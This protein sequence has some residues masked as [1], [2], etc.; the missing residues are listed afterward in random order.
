ML[1]KNNYNERLRKMEMQDKQDHFSI[2]KLSIGAA[3]VL[4]GFTFFGLN[5][6]SVKADTIDPSQNVT[7]ESNRDNSNT[8]TKETGTKDKTK[9]DAA[10]SKKKNETDLSTFSGLSSFL[11]DSKSDEVKDT[12]SKDKTDTTAKDKTDKDK[13]ET[14]DSTGNSATTPATGSDKGNQ[15]TTTDKTPTDITGSDD[16]NSDSSKLPTDVTGDTT[17]SGKDT[18]TTQDSKA[19][20]AKKLANDTANDDKTGDYATVVNGVA[21]AYNWNQF[22]NAFKND[23]CFKNVNQP[24]ETKRISEIDIMQDIYADNGSS[25]SSYKYIYGRKL[26][27]K[28]YGNER[29]KID[30]NGYDPCVRASSSE[31]LDL[32]YENLNLYSGDDY[33]VIRTDNYRK[34]C[35]VTFK[36]VEY[37]GTQLVH[38][39][40]GARIHIKGNVFA[41]TIYVPYVRHDGTNS[42]YAD[43]KQQLFEFTESNNSIDFESNCT[44]TGTTFGGNVIEMR[45]DNCN[46]TV[47]KG[48]KVT[49]NPRLNSDGKTLGNNPAENTGVVHAIYISGTGKVDV[50]GELNIN[51]GINSGDNAYQGTLDANRA[52]AIRLND[53]ASQ[54]TVESGGSVKVTTNGDISDSNTGNL[55]YDG[56]NFTVKP[57]GKLS[58]IGKHMGDYKGTL[59]Q[60][61]GIA[62]V[63]NG[64]FEIRLEEDP[65]HPYDKSDPT[66]A[67]NKDAQIFGAGTNPIVLV[68]VTGSD[69]KLIVNNPQSLVLDSHLNTATGT[70]IIGDGND[71]TITNVRQKLNFLGNSLTLPPFHT[72]QVSKDK[73]TKNIIVD[74]LVLL[75]G[76]GDENNK[77][78]FTPELW[79]KVS[80]LSYFKIPALKNIKILLDNLA[81]E[82]KPINYDTIFSKIINE[83]FSNPTNIGY[84]DIAFGPANTSGFLDIKPENV[85]ATPNVD[86]SGKKDGSWTI[87]GIVDGYKNEYD[88]PDSDPK[89]PF[90]EF[91]KLPLGTKAYIMAEIDYG[92]GTKPLSLNNNIEDPPYQ[93]T[94]NDDKKL[95]TAFAGEVTK[96]ENGNYI[97]KVNVPADVVGK[98]KSDTKIKLTPT[99]NFIDYNPLEENRPVSVNILKIAQDTA[100][101]N[102]NSKVNAAND[103]DGQFPK[104]DP[105]SKEQVAL[106]TAIN[107]AAEVAKTALDPGY[108]S[109]KSVYGAGN[110]NEVSQREENALK[111]L[112]TAMDAAQKVVKQI[113]DAKE[114]KDKAQKAIT[115][116]ANNAISRVEQQS[117]LTDAEKA[118]YIDAINSAEK[119][120]LENPSTNKNSIY[121]PANKPSDITNIQN[122]FENKVNKEAAK[123]EVAGYT[124]NGKK[125]LGVSS[126]K[127]DN[128][129]SEQLKAIDNATDIATAENDAKLNILGKLKDAAKAKVKNDAEAAKEGLGVKS[130]TKIDQAVSEA[131]KAIDDHTDFNEIKK[132]M[133]NGQNNVLSKYKDAA[134]NQLAEVAKSDKKALG[135]ESDSN[136]DQ[137]VDNA[138]TLIGQAS[139]VELVTEDLNSAKSNIADK[140]K[141]S[142]KKQ[143]QDY[144]D[145]AKSNLGVDTDTGI[146]AAAKTAEDAIDG[147][148]AASAIG[149]DITNGKNAILAAYKD[150]AKKQLDQAE[151]DIESKLENVKGLTADDIEKAKK[152]AKG[153]LTNNEKTG[154]KDKVDAAETFEDVNTATKDGIAALNKLLTDKSSLGN[155]NDA[156]DAINQARDKAINDINDKTKYP[157]LSD[158]DRNS[159]INT[160]KDDATEGVDNVNKDTDPAKIT[161]D[162]Q[163]AIDKINSVTAT[164]SSKDLA[165]LKNEQKSQTA[166]LQDAAA[167]AKETIDQID[168]KYLSP[169][170]KQYYK[171]LIDK[172]AASATNAINSASN[173]DDIDTAEKDGESNINSDLVSAQVAAAKSQAIAE[174]NKAKSDD[175][176]AI[177][178]VHKNGT[179]SDDDWEKALDAIDNAYTTAITAVSNDHTPADIVTDKNTGINAMQTVVD[180]VSGNAEQAE[181]AKT[182]NKAIADLKDQAQE[183]HDHIQADPNL[184]NTEK[185]DYLDQVASA[186][187]NAEQAVSAADK[188]T[189][190]SAHNA[191]I[192]ELNNIRNNADLQSAR[193]KAL[194][195]LQ[196][197]FN[198]D[199]AAIDGLTNISTAGKTGIKTDLQNAYNEAVNKVK[200]P[201][202][203]TIALIN[204]ASD[205]GITNM[206]NI[207]GKAKGLDQTIA[208]DQQKLEDYAQK[209]IDR[210]NSSTMSDADKGKA[211][212]DIQN[213]RDDA[214][215]EVGNKLTVEDANQAEKDGETSI[216]KAEA[217]ANQTDLNKAKDAAKA[218]IDG[219]RDKALQNLKDVYDTLTDDEKKQAQAAYNKAVKDIPALAEQAEAAIDNAFD[220]GAIS[221]L[222]NDTINSINS[223]GDTANVAMTKV[224]AVQAVKDAA[225]AAKDK[226]TNP[227]DKAGVDDVANLGIADINAATTSST[228]LDIKDNALNSIK[229]IKDS[230]TGDTDKDNALWDKKNK[231]NAELAQELAD[232]TAAIDKLTDLTSDQKK[233]FKAQAQAA[234]DRAHIRIE[235]AAETDIQSEKGIGIDNIDKALTDAKLQA[236]KNVAKA[237]VDKTADDAIDK[238][239]KDDTINKDDK[240]NIIDNINK[241]RDKTKEDIDNADTPDKVNN[242]KNDGEGEIKGHVDNGTSSAKEK[243]T[244]KDKLAAAADKIYD[245]LKNDR[246]SGKLDYNQYQDLKDKV[247]NAVDAANGAISNADGTSNINGA[248]SDGESALSGINTD[249]DK[250]E[251]V[252]T[253]LGKL[254]DAVN[255]ANDAAD[256]VAKEVGKTEKEQQKL[257]KQMKDAIEKQRAAAAKNIK[258]AQNAAD[259]PLNAIKTAGQKGVDSITGLTNDYTDKVDQIKTLKQKA[260]AAK[261]DLNNLKT[262]ENGNPVLTAS[263][264][265]QGEADIDDAVQT[266][267]SD[268]YQASSVDDA[269]TAEQKAEDAVGL[270]KLPTELLAEKNKQI[271]AINQYAADADKTIDGFAQSD[272]NKDGLPADTIAELKAQV[273]AAKK[274]AISKINAV[275]LAKGASQGDF[276]KAKDK[277]DKAEKGHAESNETVDFG[278]AGIDK[279]KTLAKQKADVVKAKNDKI[280]ELEQK[281]KD[282]NN[283]IE[284]SGMSPADQGPLKDQVQKLV[285]KAKD[286]IINI[287]DTDD[288]GNVKTPEQVKDEA[289]TIIN[290]TVDGFKDPDDNNK[291]PGISDIINNAQLEGA[292]TTAEKTL[293]NKR[294]QA[295]DIINGSQ[296]TADQKQ[297]ANKAIDDAFNTE[298]SDIDAK[299]NIND[300]PKDE[301]QIG[302]AIDAIWNKPTSSDEKNEWFNDEENNALSG[303][304]GVAG[305]ETEAGLDKLTDKQK[306]DY[307]DYIDDITNAITAIKDAKNIKDASSAYDKGMTSLNKL[308]ALEQVKADA[309]KAKGD[310][311]KSDL[312]DTA[313]DRLKGDVEKVVEDTKDKLNQI[314]SSIGNASTNKDKIDQITHDAQSDISTIKD[315]FGIEDQSNDVVNANDEISK[316]HSD[317]IDTI[318]NEFGDDS[319]TPKTDDAYEKNKHVHSTTDEGI[320]SDKTNADKEISKGAIDDAADIAKDKVNHLKHE[321]GTDYTDADKN[322][323]NEQ[324]DKDAK[325]AKD[326]IDKADKVTDIDNIRNNGIH[327][328]HQD[329]SDPATIDN[330][331]HGN[332]SN[333]N[334]GGGGVVAPIQPA[335]PAKKPTTT[336]TSD[337]DKPNGTNVDLSNASDVTLMHNAYLYDET[338]KRANK[339]TLGAGSVLTTYDTKTING[340]DYYVLVDKGANNK[341]YYV[342]VGNVVA[343]TRKLKHNAYIYNQFGKRVKNT[344]VF[345]KGKLIKTFGNAVKIRG[346]KYFII[347]KNRFVKAANFAKGVVTVSTAKVEVV[348]TSAVAEKPKTIVEKTLMHNA[349]LYDQNGTRANKLIFQAGSKVG[350][351]GKK[352]VNG[353]VCYE[354]PDGMFIAAGNIDAKKLKLKH[355]AYVYNQYGH[356]ANKKVLKK[357]K[358]VKTYGNSVKINGK[359]YFIISKGRFVKKANF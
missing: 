165:D 199:N 312:N 38:S 203:N 21:H 76:Q 254:S 251:A 205:A 83:A 247:D 26:L 137:A 69:S 305:L 339:I 240:Q 107:N 236:V 179:L 285:D 241:D 106:E 131:A 242:A 235:G 306:A 12:S 303:T 266:G 111:D 238:V 74:K 217:N 210:I 267:I 212:K 5:S 274:K 41:E 214:Q 304:D 183:L 319:K 63:Q 346:K 127:I 25:N 66:S 270:A 84:N 335:N 221:D 264:V 158:E 342:A 90:R 331:L 260:D 334:N 174:L 100:A 230:G 34:G 39:T 40:S 206:E 249:I 126:D 333:D 20:E 81:D 218:R 318:H 332:N 351:V 75:N 321:D 219:A 295:H 120:A 68:D 190:N 60:I 252:N 208:D 281:Q 37:H 307:K 352:T 142:A 290:N 170:D 180:S 223:T 296:L 169:S 213:A 168:N 45:G 276:D 85:T 30:F 140:F 139:S 286:Q 19:N 309:D 146:D 313:K 134:K 128:A 277:V 61:A 227:R 280:A 220:K 233:Q 121:N 167:K 207:L 149:T 88:G 198:T 10:A 224:V 96:S 159:L 77:Y 194:T 71:V 243:Q 357:R 192:E 226:L 196:N 173:K 50:K 345:K 11:K 124:E 55:I 225:Q 9:A 353:K 31:A 53:K 216:Q 244:A 288:K 86:A 294:A 119:V 287:S 347:D 234:H 155:K 245:R 138:N 36:N 56:G 282:A 132:D 187:N 250:V 80:Q 28:S 322:K 97:F 261:D 70:S 184:S 18:D 102:I 326:K 336:N 354:L 299:T 162:K 160:I 308:K 116:A 185:N 317:A 349:Y 3:S 145:E 49:L 348:P 215:G 298:K 257:A 22:L 311:D 256:A 133:T 232:T 148:T 327:Q 2:R 248:E 314:D 271:A 315:D 32:T 99:A 27:V 278:E 324:I 301:D 239:N 229:N 153:L 95:P 356:R 103:L 93:Y 98:I 291:V 67:Q 114:A 201:A 151:K 337:K 82:N 191:G 1:G 87:S 92:K 44:F 182:K 284:N 195:D 8:E 141:D 188:N 17:N 204:S 58:I 65:N 166:A 253:A 150:S 101:N 109:G 4:L 23:E 292:K 73:K 350:T 6:Q 89:N 147:D 94:N 35:D 330:I 157:N 246:N 24:D 129:L 33:G 176:K 52:T 228:V 297:K 122:A 310:I 262:D 47:E 177:N 341:K 136:I 302:Q 328:I 163:A 338:G 329:C 222:T 112:Q 125:T 108:E 156:I 200:D 231:A 43:N 117:A 172:H 237:D 273:E 115:T 343:A 316:N 340:K 164:A 118:Q 105:K 186:L 161:A 175:K 91:L 29:R 14:S 320:N 171:D 42:A 154:Y 255:K 359:R 269:K 130:D 268:I 181:L 16:Q 272:Q 113:H 344:G 279:V 323:I 62:N 289:D 211:I 325:D 300:V 283:D 197:E 355:N 202:S 258:D 123:A 293:N 57:D 13:Q 79:E 178:D 78:M 143:V 59:V 51:V 48:A 144:A 275:T 46:V 358:S 7:E 72:L 189:V 259:D 54:F 152:V 110:V 15:D 265:A 64:T 135:V 263:D 193:D 209:A 104:S